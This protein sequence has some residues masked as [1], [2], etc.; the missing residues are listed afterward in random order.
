MNAARQALPEEDGWLP[1]EKGLIVREPWVSMLMDGTKVWE[2]R[3]SATRIRGRV[4]LI[5]S[6]SGLVLGEAVLSGCRGP[7]SREDLAKSVDR[8]RVGFDW[9]NCPMPYRNVY[10][11]EMSDARRY[12][13]PVPYRHP[14]GAVIWVGLETA[15]AA[16]RA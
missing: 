4:G 16:L 9:A 13:R 5:R 15:T 8:H 1:P 2:L 3:G 7:L 11:W 12:E 14:Q 10:A 6:A